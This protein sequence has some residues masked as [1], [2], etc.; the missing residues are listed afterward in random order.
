MRQ[1]ECKV[2]IQPSTSRAGGNP[3]SARR[4]SSVRGAR[5]QAWA[6]SLTEVRLWHISAAPERIGA[7]ALLF[8]S[9]SRAA[10]N[11]CALGVTGE[12]TIRATN[13]AHPSRTR[14]D[15]SA[16]GATVE[17]QRTRDSRDCEIATRNAVG[18]FRTQHITIRSAST[19]VRTNASR[20]IN[21]ADGP[22]RTNHC[23]SNSA[24]AQYLTS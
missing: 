23:S 20:S 14:S 2:V 12:A 19:D 8:N 15:T 10:R 1:T 6:N 24:D 16:S 11:N 18:A 5:P 17:S 4:H 22:S 13:S 21:I 7:A 9:E 3:A